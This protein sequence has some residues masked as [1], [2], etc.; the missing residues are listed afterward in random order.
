VWATEFGRTSPAT[1]LGKITNYKRMVICIGCCKCGYFGNQLRDIPQ[2]EKRVILTAQIPAEKEYGWSWYNID[3]EYTA[4]YYYFISALN[5]TGP[6]NNNTVKIRKSDGSAEWITITSENCGDKDS[7]VSLVEAQNWTWD[8]ARNNSFTA[9]GIWVSPEDTQRSPD[10]PT[11][12]DLHNETEW[13]TLGVN[14]LPFNESFCQSINGGWQYIG[15]GSRSLGY[16]IWPLPY[17]INL[18]RGDS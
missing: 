8:I 4:Y 3:G 12:N 13:V 7:I 11:L 14:N 2:K 15:L 17:P 18:L 5:G 1:F 9:W 6:Y 16:S 10:Q